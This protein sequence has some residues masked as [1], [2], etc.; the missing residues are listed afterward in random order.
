MQERKSGQ[1]GKSVEPFLSWQFSVKNKNAALKHLFEKKDSFIQI[2]LWKNFIASKKKSALSKENSSAFLIK[3]RCFP[4]IESWFPS[5]RNAS[6][7]DCTFAK[8]SAN[9]R[10]KIVSSYNREKVS[11]EKEKKTT[12]SSISTFFNTSKI[13]EEGKTPPQAKADD[14]I[15]HKQEK[16]RA[17]WV[18][19]LKCSSNKLGTE[20]L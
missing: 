9:W 2:W 8:R 12:A 13:F 16:G 10:K 5:C 17:Y 7:D 14:E 11:L 1:S 3:R 20:P 18:F 19:I 6:G 15:I 4:S